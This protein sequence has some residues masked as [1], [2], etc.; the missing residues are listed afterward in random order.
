MIHELKTWPNPFEASW[1]GKKPYEIRKFDRDFKVGDKVYLREYDPDK[2]RYT[3]RSIE[4]VITYM[5]LPGNWGIP[6]DMCV[7]SF[8]ELAQFDGRDECIE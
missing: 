4:G 6:M 7:F 1:Q 8:D 5:T 2:K 3:G